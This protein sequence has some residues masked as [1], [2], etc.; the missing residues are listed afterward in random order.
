M[1]MGVSHCLRMVK[2]WL[3]SKNRMHRWS[4]SVSLTTIR[5]WH[6]RHFNPQT[7]IL[8]RYQMWAA[9]LDTRLEGVQAVGAAACTGQRTKSHV[10]SVSQP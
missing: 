4:N 1:S 10:I 8:P 3:V 5:G 7:V 6:M 9:R 2:R